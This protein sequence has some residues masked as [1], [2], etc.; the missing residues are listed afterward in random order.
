ML[1]R[2]DNDLLTQVGPDTPMGTLMRRFW[3]PVLLAREIAEPDCTPVRVRLLGEPLI[4]FRDT[5][6]RV[7]VVDE[8]CPHRLSSLFFG[9]NE[10][11]GIRCLYH[12]WKFD[13]DGNCVDMPSEPPDSN[14]RT[15]VRLKA[16]PVRELGGV[17]WAYMGPPE[18]MGE[19]PR[20]EWMDLPAEQQYASRWVQ[21]CNY[22]QCV[23]GEIDSA[24]VSFLHSL[25]NKT[26]EQKTAL[27]GAYFAGDR[28]P[29]WKVVDT[30]YGMVLGARR[31]TDDGRYYWRM[32]QW[33]LPFYTMIA[34]V[35]G[36]ARSF[37][38]WV[39]SDDTHCS[40]LCVSYRTDGPVSEDE[41]QRWERGEAQHAARIPGTLT[42][43]ANAGND[44]LIDREVQRTQ[45][46]SGIAGIR[47]QDAAMV[48][49]AG[50][51]SDR[52]REHLGTSDTAV[53]RMRR[54]LLG[55]AKA[56][57]AGEEPAAAQGG[58]L[59]GVRSHSV[60]IDADGDFDAY[61]EI[62]EAM[63]V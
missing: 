38:M 25:V 54:L 6:G 24:H 5:E 11:C 7:G 17:V 50:P 35:P 53:I 56:L 26:T 28:A 42:P 4:A 58:G 2:E 10:D 18:R 19:P 8:H 22:A 43:V 45:T 46:F 32:N 23:E 16:Y 44:Y 63:R 34:P 15:K 36:E 27:T 60:V 3:M 13:V 49:S 31:Q 61:P 39:P 62:M 37:R 57:Q 21:D 1:S 20:F 14:F 33:Y 12:G 40:I 55:A 52:T 47:A 29:K 41:V 48:E 59:Y 9:R 30:D 51:I